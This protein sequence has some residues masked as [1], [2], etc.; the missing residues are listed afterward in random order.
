MG[1]RFVSGLVLFSIFLLS[2]TV[3]AEVIL[4]QP[5]NVYNVGDLLSVSVLV[6]PSSSTTD[7]L[8]VKMKC[9]NEI[10]LYRNTL[11]ISSSETREIVVD[12]LLT[13]N[14]IGTSKGECYLEAS[15]NQEA[16][17]SQN[18]ELTDV[19]DVES[20]LQGAFPAEPGSVIISQGSAYKKNGQ[21]VNGA[22]TARIDN[23]SLVSSLIN[24]GSFS[25]EIVL[26]ENTAAGSH[27]LVIEVFEKDNSGRVMNK[28]A[29]TKTITVKAVLKRIQIVIEPYETEPNST[30]TYKIEAF[31]QTDQIL[32]KDARVDI[33]GSSSEEA[34]E[35]L[36]TTSRD[37][38]FFVPNDGEAGYWRVE[39]NVDGT[40]EKKLFYVK[41]LELASFEV[42]D[43]IL[44]V[45]NIGNVPYIKTI[46]IGIGNHT[47]LKEVNLGVGEVKK[48]RLSA[49][50][51]LYDIFVGDG[52]S[53]F[54][55][56]GIPL[57]GGV[58]G[59]ND[60]GSSILS[61][62]ALWF[63][64]LVIV[65]LGIVGNFYIRRAK[66]GNKKEDL[67]S[68]SSIGNVSRNK[69]ILAGTKESANAIAL[70][71]NNNS[72]DV[73]N[74]VIDLAKGHGAHVYKDG[75]HYMMIL[76]QSLTKNT[77]TDLLAVKTA[78]EIGHLLQSEK[79]EFGIGVSKGEFVSSRTD[80]TFS[81][82][83]LSNF[84]P[85][86][87]RMAREA[88]KEVLLSHDIYVNIMSSIKAEK[89]KEANAW[90]LKSVIDRDSQGS[91]ISGFL[92]RNKFS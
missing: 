36:T 61:K 53:K 79:R 29:E 50:E 7:F 66:F 31:D 62:S 59:V 40:V 92:R 2:Y 67:Y 22:V 80:G 20:N 60:L 74:R 56:K 11:S 1:K 18:F 45:K 15:Y 90:R 41:E 19:I 10:E 48:F 35:S 4:G 81:F 43:N 76:S 52:L 83:S 55:M 68:K 73:I 49:P 8:S 21:L 6:H 17:R 3:S 57:T 87:K 85:S 72:S 14:I 71:A 32:Y 75:E 77:N 46:E 33:F 13:P 84:I 64:L 63:I 30:I 5:K 65:A 28:G 27:E 44:N 70:L 69:E 51:N 38:S 12:S 39:A 86:A 88:D 58:I 9:N 24:N 25:F 16:V 23:Q 37:N 54:E 42:I 26:P 34:Y 78:N 47:E 89:S 91:F 82:S